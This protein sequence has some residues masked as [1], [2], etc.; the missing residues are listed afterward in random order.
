MFDMIAIPEDGSPD[1]LMA[2]VDNKETAAKI[3]R[4][5]AHLY[6]RKLKDYRVEPRAKAQAVH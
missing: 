1:F 3:W 5:T 2:I 6:S 4:E